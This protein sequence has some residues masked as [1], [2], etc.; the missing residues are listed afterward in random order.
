[1]K[2]DVQGIAKWI[3][4]NQTVIC[5]AS[6]QS[7]FPVVVAFYAMFLNLSYAL[8]IMRQQQVTFNCMGKRLLE[9]QMFLRWFNLVCETK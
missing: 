7:A 9:L 1:M 2:A 6:V 5:C 3:E 8:D 4:L